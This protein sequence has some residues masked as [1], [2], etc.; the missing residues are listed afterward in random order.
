MRNMRFLAKLIND[1][2][3]EPT[4]RVER[5]P[6]LVLISPCVA[7]FCS[8]HRE[9]S[10]VLTRNARQLCEQIYTDGIRIGQGEAL[11]AVRHPTNSRLIIRI[12]VLIP[13]Q[14]FASPFRS[15]RSRESITAYTCELSNGWSRLCPRVTATLICISARFRHYRFV[16]GLFRISRSFC[17]SVFLSFSLFPLYVPRRGQI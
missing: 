5:V 15:F 10:T 6:R 7:N 2:L 1:Q 3:V 14:S 11:F 17:L 16:V 12:I 13:R 9:Q 4:L 8:F